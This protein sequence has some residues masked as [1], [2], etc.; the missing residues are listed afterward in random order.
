MLITPN[1]R[2][3]W[4]MVKVKW[5]HVHYQLIGTDVENGVK[6]LLANPL[7]QTVARIAKVLSQVVEN[8]V[9]GE[10]FEYV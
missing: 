1:R 8:F 9:T 5:H 7:C 10:E 4:E 6:G 3:C 2:S